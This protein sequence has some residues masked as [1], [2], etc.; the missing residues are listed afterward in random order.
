VHLLPALPSALPTGSIRGLRLR[1]GHELDLVWAEGRLTQAVIR[2]G[3]AGEV[4][5]RLGGGV[6]RLRLDAGQAATIA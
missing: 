1:G 3:T 6:R 5:V 2:A 4:A